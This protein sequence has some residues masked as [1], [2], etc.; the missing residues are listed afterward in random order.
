MFDMTETIHNPLVLPEDLPAPQD[1][2]ATCHLIGM[3]L[4]DLA[5]A[6]TDGTAVNP[7]KLKG[8]ACLRLSPHRAAR[9][10][11]ANRLGC[12]PRR[13]RL[14]AA[15]LRISRSFHRLEAARG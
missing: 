14:H 4:P 9:P 3:R 5:L 2:G 10:G 15:I 11:L 12:D 1:D 13:A 6:A 7:S 8:R